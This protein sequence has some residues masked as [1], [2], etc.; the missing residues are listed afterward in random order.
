MTASTLTSRFLPS[1]GAAVSP[2]RRSWRATWALWRRRA[3][4]RAELA[5]MDERERKDLGIT[6]ADVS[7]EIAK[8]VW[9]G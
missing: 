6:A 8:P 4:E 1:A 3:R 9:R 2:P 7:M 5:R